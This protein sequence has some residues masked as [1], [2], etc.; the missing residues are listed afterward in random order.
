MKITIILL[1]V[2]LAF[3]PTVFAETYIVEEVLNCNTLKLSTGETVRLIGLECP[4][5]KL[6][7]EATEFVKRHTKKAKDEKFRIEFDVQKR[8]KYGRLLVYAFYTDTDENWPVP[9]EDGV[10][11][12]A[13]IIFSGYV[14]PLTIPPN[15]KYAEL[16]QN[17]FRDAVINK[18][19]L[20][21]DGVS[22]E[23][24]LKIKGKWG[25]FGLFPQEQCNIPSK[26][27][28]KICR[29]ND[30]CEG[31]CIADLTKEQFKRVVEQHV[32]LKVNGQCSGWTLNYGCQA[33]VENGTVN[34]ILCID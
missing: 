24:C 23:T 5:D 2:I 11:L 14:Q 1:T 7:K 13:W 12:N 21:K 22:Q 15:V 18:S 19:G 6:G 31:D 29:N 16:F 25:Q 34:S 20:W 4:K 30:D 33:F 26:D 32:V 8:D 10:M 28:G 3:S 27:K 9:E 17:L